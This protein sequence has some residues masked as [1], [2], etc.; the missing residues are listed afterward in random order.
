MAE[1]KTKP[2]KVSAKAFVEG[3]SDESKR[4]DAKTLLK[5][6]AAATGEKPVMW[7]PSIIGYGS[8][9]YKYDSG[10]EGDSCLVGFSPRAAALTPAR[11]SPRRGSAP[12]PQPRRHG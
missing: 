10:R 11:R 4:S 1:N 6:F 5:I 2:T 9:H 12:R 3:I 8:Y 7:G